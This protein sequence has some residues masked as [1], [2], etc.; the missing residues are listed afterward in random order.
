M[1]RSPH[2]LA[3]TITL[4]V[5]TLTLILLQGCG[6]SAAAARPSD[7]AEAV[8]VFKTF[9]GALFRSETATI[10]RLLTRKSLL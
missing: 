9:Q 1:A 8:R 5:I 3:R 10:R 2:P 4:G 6:H 7:E